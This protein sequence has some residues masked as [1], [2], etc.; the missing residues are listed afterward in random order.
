MYNSKKKKNEEQKNMKNV[1]IMLMA[2]LLMAACATLTP[3]QKAARE[4]AAKAYL[5][6]ALVSQKYKINLTSIRPMRGVERTLAGPWIRVDSTTVE[7][8]MPM[9]VLTTFLTRRL[10][11][12]YVWNHGSSSSLRCQ[13][14]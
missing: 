10:A 3:E 4:A 1:M 5:K 7:C 12:R 14:M 9:P 8:E 13:T 6:K 2:A 11:A